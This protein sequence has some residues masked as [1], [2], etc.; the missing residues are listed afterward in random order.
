MKKIILAALPLVM[1]TAAAPANAQEKNTEFRPKEVWKDT[2]GNAINAHGGGI[3]YHNG[4][5]YWYGEY[6]VG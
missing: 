2:D 4:T 6:K 5:Y 1:L 3:M